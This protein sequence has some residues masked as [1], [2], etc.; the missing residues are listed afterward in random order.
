MYESKGEIFPDLLECF[1]NTII[2]IYGQQN[3]RNMKFISELISIFF[4][5]IKAA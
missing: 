1:A 2:K 5:D 3:R 4:Q